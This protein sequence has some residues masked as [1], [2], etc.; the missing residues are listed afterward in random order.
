MANNLT[1][2]QV[3]EFKKAFLLLDKDG[4]AAITR[5]ELDTILR[6]FGENPTENELREMINEADCN[7]SG[8]IKFP[9]FLSM[10]VHKMKSISED[11]IREF[12]RI[13]DNNGNS[14]ITG[15]EIIQV[16]RNIREKLTDEEIGA[17]IYQADCDCD[18]YISYVLTII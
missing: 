11:E 13:F 15:G 1:E 18:G 4:D 14:H 6:T 8:I 17:M 7:G 2:R 5:K 16:M 3:A 9:E 12:C 10:M